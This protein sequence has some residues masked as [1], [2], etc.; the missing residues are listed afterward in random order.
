M[1]SDIRF[2]LRTFARQPSFAFAAVATLALGIA[3]NTLV[4]SLVNSL[5][6]RPMPVPFASRVHRLYPVSASGR[7]ENLFS[8]PDYEDYRRG[9]HVFETLAAYIPADLTAGRSSLDRS[10]V[11]P[12]AVL[13]YAVSASYFDLT[14]VRA[15]AG[16]IL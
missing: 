14:S 12:R 15:S 6:L 8:V 1:L 16:R 3:V 13:G 10:V 11:E 9:A 2:A 4:F 7:R 5:A